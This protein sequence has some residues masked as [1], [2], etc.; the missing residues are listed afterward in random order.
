MLEFGDMRAEDEGVVYVEMGM[1]HFGTV[2]HREFRKSH[3]CR[4]SHKSLGR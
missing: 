4:I 2:K 3:K 1:W